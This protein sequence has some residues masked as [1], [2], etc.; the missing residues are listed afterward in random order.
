[1]R[2]GMGDVTLALEEI[3]GTWFR[4][5]TMIHSHLL[6]LRGPFGQYHHIS[7][8]G[9]WSVPSE[10]GCGD[11]NFLARVSSTLAV[12]R[13][14]RQRLRHQ[15]YG[16]AVTSLRRHLA[17]PTGSSNGQVDEPARLRIEVPSPLPIRHRY[18]G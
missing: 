4:L 15:Y 14:M 3:S 18:H 6:A 13:L 16:Q 11:F 7:L 9:L 2:K 1:M 17:S 8:R 5:Q 12:E 10:S